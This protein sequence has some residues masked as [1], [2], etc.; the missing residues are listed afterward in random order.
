[1]TTIDTIRALYDTERRDLVFP[2]W[3]REATAHVV[4][5]LGPEHA[6]TAMISWSQLT[7]ENADEVI[8]GEIAYFSGLGRRFEWKLYDHDQPPD[9][10]ARLAAHGFEI[11]DDEAIMVRALADLPA[12]LLAPV[13]HDVRRIDDPEQLD[14]VVAVQQAVWGGDYSWLREHLAA[15]L[16]EGPEWL[17]VY[18]AY[19]DGRPA[20][21]A[22]I[23]FAPGSAFA[24]L[25]GGSTLPEV[26]GRGLYTALLALRAQEARAR[27]V[28]YLT[29]D[30]SPMSR[31]IVERF[32]FQLMSMSNPCEWSVN[33]DKGAGRDDA[34]GHG[35]AGS[36]PASTAAPAPPA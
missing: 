21:S 18:V 5:M 29:I 8:A 26:R 35:E 1:M 28:P 19:L 11:G 24:G 9:L 15:Q 30:A 31:R 36:R 10:K 22:W 33:D 7:P 3:R 25:W 23:T 6:R 32:G 17:S 34:Q 2:G 16:R 27:G 4:R 20:T 14:D 13:T 12:E